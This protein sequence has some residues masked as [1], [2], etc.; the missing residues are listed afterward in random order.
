MYS[1]KSKVEL[2]GQWLEN[3]C[4]KLKHNVGAASNLLTEMKEHLETKKVSVAKKETLMTSVTY[5]ENKKHMKKY[6]KNYKEKIS[7]W[8]LV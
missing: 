7:N 1:G 3:A 8:G 2:K 5:F 4:H 6:A